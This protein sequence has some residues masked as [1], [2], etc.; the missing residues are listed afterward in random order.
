MSV[1]TSFQ[2]RIIKVLQILRPPPRLTTSQWADQYRRLSSETSAEPGRW[3]TSRAPYQKGLMDAA[4][5][6]SIE[7]IVIMSS[8][9]V[10]KTEV[11]NTI[12]GKHVHQDPCPILVVQPTLEM[13]Q[14]WSRRFAVMARDTPVLKGLIK[15]PKAKDSGNTLLHKSFPGGSLNKCSAGKLTSSAQVPA[16]RSRMARSPGW[17]SGERL[18]T[19]SPQPS[20][21]GTAGSSGFTP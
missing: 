12:V 17:K 14:I 18:S 8:A 4:D 5:D 7:W 20:M 3:Q 6:P 16:R 10:G 21:P 15:D 1:Q 2:S 9:Q 19:T 13:A 11:I